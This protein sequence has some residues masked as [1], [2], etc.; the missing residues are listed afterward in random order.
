MSDSEDEAAFASADEGEEVNK[1]ALPAASA[2]SGKKEK[3]NT[4]GA[5]QP[6]AGGATATTKTSSGDSATA[7]KGEQTK[8][9]KG[10]QQQQ[11][12]KKK[13]KA[14]SQPSPKED[15]KT[16]S[17]E[18]KA[19][20]VPQTAV[21]QSKSDEDVT[22]KTEATEK[23]Q[24]VPQAKSDTSKSSQDKEKGK[25]DKSAGEDKT[26]SKSDSTVSPSKSAEVVQSDNEPGTTTPKKERSAEKESVDN[27]KTVQAGEVRKG[28]GAEMSSPEGQDI[29]R[30]L[31]DQATP[32][33]DES[34]EKS[35][36]GWGWG[37]WGTSILSAASSSVQTFTTQVGDGFTTIIDTMES[38]LGVPDPGELAQAKEVKEPEDEGK[39]ASAD[40]EKDTHPP[41]EKSSE[42]QKSS[43]MDKRV[44][45]KDVKEKSEEKPEEQKEAESSSGNSWFSSWGVA[46]LAKKVQDTGKTLATKGQTLMS[47]G[48]DAV[49]NLAAGGIDVLE[50]IGKKTYSTLSEHDPAL[51]KTREFLSPKA[52]KP[53]LSSVLREAKDQAEIQAEQEKENE[54]ARKAHFGTLFDDYQGIAHLEALEML[55]NQS[56]K[57]VHSLLNSLA[58]EDLT[59]IKPVLIAIKEAFE[60]N[61]DD[62]DD[63]DLA[64]K[65]QDFTSLVS[66]HLSELELGTAPDKLNKVH[67]M[68]KQWIV[69]FDANES[70]DSES[71]KNVHQRSIQSLAELTSKG[72]EQF[73]KAGELVLLERDTDKDCTE[74]AH[75]LARL[76]GVLCHEVG[77]M[78]TK[79]AGCLNKMAEQEESSDEITALVTNI[80]LEASN[81]STYLQD[82][83]Q[84]LLPV[85]Q[86]AALE[87]SIN[88]RHQS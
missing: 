45:D 65:D 18:K 7:G 1:P 73:H 9:G 83:F 34:A 20:D 59:A 5:A 25:G 81:S 48:F 84:L 47:E 49:E 75:S 36:G 82:A 51:R 43:A 3:A 58:S 39:S 68:V 77:N 87:H 72:V 8:K 76:T 69:D 26:A 85:L 63:A 12:G 44:P 64:A 29:P 41:Q 53:N 14:S 6:G 52:D 30:E 62:D 70:H 67:E 27:Q 86:Q 37:S 88:S 15:S 78:A 79:F 2:A 80:Y 55:S 32:K 60:V 74:R 21:K 61:E 54:E 4:K 56:E 17:D 35:S 38:S 19:S 23:E 31:K 57:K 11:K 71:V 40:G 50:T 66:Q 33:Q 24:S 28:L 22:P 46:D 10:R 16:E 13:G 42:G